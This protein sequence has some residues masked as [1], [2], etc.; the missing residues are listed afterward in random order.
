M[1]GHYLASCYGQFE[2]SN[3][4]TASSRVLPM[5]WVYQYKV[6]LYYKLKDLRRQCKA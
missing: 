5:D 6:T 4:V 1:F 3:P 2:Y